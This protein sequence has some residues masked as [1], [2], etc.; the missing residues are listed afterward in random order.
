[1]RLLVKEVILDQSRAHG[2]VWF[3]INWQTGA[4]SEHWFVRRVTGYA[5]YAHLE[6]LQQRIRDLAAQG[7]MDDEIA[8]TLN[9]EGYRTAHGFDFTSKLLWMLRHEWQIPAAKVNGEHPLRWEDG[10]YSVEGAAAA[11]GVHMSTIYNW[12]TSSRI[13][14]QQLRKGT[15]WKIPLTEEQIRDLKIHVQRAR[16]SKKEAS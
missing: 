14:G 7:K 11:I 8:A 6:A 10:S 5:E 9:A 13:Q 16:R 2:M 1:M 4:T 3:Q 15:P 12:L